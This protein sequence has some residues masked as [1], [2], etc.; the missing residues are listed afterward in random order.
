MN[1][2]MALAVSGLLAVIGVV[3][4]EFECK[5]AWF[6]ITGS[7][8]AGLCGLM[9]IL[10][11]AKQSLPRAWSWGRSSLQLLSAQI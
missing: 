9:G 2:L 6:L 4:T 11:V 7:V 5:V 8:S 3:I 10:G 1:G